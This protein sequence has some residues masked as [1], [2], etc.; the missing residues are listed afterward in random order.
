MCEEHGGQ[1][2]V[3]R[4]ASSYLSRTHAYI[5]LSPLTHPYSNDLLSQFLSRVPVMKFALYKSLIAHTCILIKSVSSKSVKSSQVRYIPHAMT[6]T[7]DSRSNV[8]ISLSL[9]LDSPYR[10]NHPYVALLRS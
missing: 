3:S 10:V 1:G 6:T 5:L 2:R 4:A 8:N 9:R 7:N